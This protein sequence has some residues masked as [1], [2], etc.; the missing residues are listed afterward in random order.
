MNSSGLPASSG[1]H[2]E[3]SV[4]GALKSQRLGGT[5]TVDATIGRILFIDLTHGSTHLTKNG[6]GQGWRREIELVDGGGVNDDKERYE[7]IV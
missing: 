2:E 6:N 3:Q 5:V 4:N 7:F 1:G